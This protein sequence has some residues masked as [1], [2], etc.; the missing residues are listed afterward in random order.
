MGGDSA[1]WFTRDFHLLIQVRPTTGTSTD[2]DRGIHIK[3]GIAGKEAET[4]SQGQEMER[5]QP[6]SRISE[7]KTSAASISHFQ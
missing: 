1:S 3:E 5:Q 7:F 6:E 2:R 4:K